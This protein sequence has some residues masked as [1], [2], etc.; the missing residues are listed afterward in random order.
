[1]AHQFWFSYPPPTSGSS[2]SQTDEEK[3]EKKEAAEALARAEHFQ[4]QATPP[5][6]SGY[7]SAAVA[8]EARDGAPASKRPPPCFKGTGYWRLAL[9]GADRQP[10]LHGGVRHGG[11]ARVGRFRPVG[12]RGQHQGGAA[13]GGQSGGQLGEHAVARQTTVTPGLRYRNLG[14]S[15]LRVSNVGLGTW[16]TFSSGVT[17]EAAEQIVL[18]A[19]DSGINVFDLSEAYS[20]PRAELELGRILQ[21]HGWKRSSYI[22][23]TKIYWNTKSDERGLSRKHVIESVKASLQRL[24]LTYIDV[25]IVH[26]ADPMCP[27]EEVVRAMNHVISQGWAMYWGTARWTPVEVM[28]AYTNCRQFNCVTPICEQAEYHMF[29]R[30]K[31]ELYMPELYNKI[32]VGLMAWSPLTMGL[33]SGKV[34]DSGMPLFTR[35]SFKNKYSSFSWTEDET[36]KEGFT[37]VKDRSGG[38]GGGGGG[39]GDD[40]PREPAPPARRPQQEKVRDVAQLAERLGCSVQQL[41]IAWGLKNES[42][43]CLLLGAASA[44]QL[45][46][47]I[48]SLQLVPKLTSSTM[49]ELERILDNKPARPPMVSTLALR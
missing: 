46:E 14:K 6:R 23:T 49:A 2:R 4:Q 25:V 1:M 37:W 40:T 36:Q 35:P 5:P 19:Y 9:P 45:Y 24:Q 20:G 31:T 8:Y 18:L 38:G 27:M 48:Q 29:C 30:D 47:S 11:G 22:V 33:V 21:R 12:A 13:D 39:G 41:A 16:V 15:G 44:D 7:R 17:E 3:K 26:K 10:G 32:G 28:E 34:D 43:Q 42:V